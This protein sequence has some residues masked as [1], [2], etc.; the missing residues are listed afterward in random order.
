[1][2]VDHIGI[3]VRNLGKA[4]E[5]YRNLFDDPEIEMEISADQSMK[6]A[7]IKFDNMNIELLE[8]QNDESVIA[9]YIKKK[10]EGIHHIAFKVEDIQKSIRKAE[11][12][13]LKVLG[14]P[15]IGSH[16]NFITF[17]HPK[18]MNGVLTELCQ[19]I[20]EKGK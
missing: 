14:P 5:K 20:K 6:I 10:G 17:L 16:N 15:R 4:I 8:A 12:K 3:A 7:H 1:M 19:G 11:E 2:K 13:G 9:G 18:D